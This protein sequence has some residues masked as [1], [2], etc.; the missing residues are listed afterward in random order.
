MIFIVWL[1]RKSQDNFVL[2]EA[3]MFKKLFLYCC[4]SLASAASFAENCDNELFK[5]KKIS[6]DS[7]YSELISALDEFPGCSQSYGLLGGKAVEEVSPHTGVFCLRGPCCP[8]RDF[9]LKKLDAGRSFLRKAISIDRK[10]WWSRMTL[11]GSYGSMVDWGYYI[12]QEKSMGNNRDKCDWWYMGDADQFMAIFYEGIKE[13]SDP[14]GL[15]SFIWLGLGI[16]LKNDD[17]R[18]PEFLLEA[19]KGKIRKAAI[20]SLERILPKINEAS[21]HDAERTLVELKTGIRPSQ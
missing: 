12:P 16:Y 4:I 6:V 11:L 14:E 20:K 17:Q 2:S 5:Q 7:E 18:A 8:D 9:T 15:H 13:I 10:D 3:L 1:L 21:R 19:Q